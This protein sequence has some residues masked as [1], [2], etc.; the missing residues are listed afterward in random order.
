MV[1]GERHCFLAVPLM[2]VPV[3]V[4]MNR[5]SLKSSPKVMKKFT[6]A[7]LTSS[8]SAFVPVQVPGSTSYVACQ[9]LET[10]VPFKLTSIRPDAFPFPSYM[11]LPPATKA[12]SINAQGSVTARNNT[13]VGR[14]PWCI[15]RF[16]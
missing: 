10:I 1:W 11:V 13:D 16:A 14:L 6:V 3:S 5:S 2:A 8:V 7:P 9:A 4:A 12:P 15:R